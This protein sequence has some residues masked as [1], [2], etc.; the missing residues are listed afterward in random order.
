MININ[1]KNIDERKV[2][3][4][5]VKTVQCLMQANI[6]LTKKSM[7]GESYELVE[8]K[9]YGMIIE[10]NKFTDK[11]DSLSKFGLKT[12]LATEV[13]RGLTDEMEREDMHVVRYNCMLP[14]G[15]IK[16]VKLNQVYP[17]NIDTGTENNTQ[18]VVLKYKAQILDQEALI[19]ELG[20]DTII[21]Y[22]NY[23][24]SD[25]NEIIQKLEKESLPE[26]PKES[27]ESRL[28]KLKSLKE[29][30]LIDETTYKNKLSE[31][32]TEL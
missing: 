25:V 18:K 1:G 31:L 15:T 21:L 32:M 19:I 23:D 4:Y 30:G 7:F 3:N 22:K 16:K 8:Y 26:L 14:N 27:I 2:T 11:L 17:L 12:T 6:K 28:I 5:K 24:Y 9:P 10:E 20:T 29:A 13:I